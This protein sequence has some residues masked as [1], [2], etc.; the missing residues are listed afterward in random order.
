[1]TKTYH[2]VLRI[3]HNKHNGYAVEYKRE[4]ED[5]YTSAKYWEDYYTK[6]AYCFPT[7]RSV[8]VVNQFVTEE[9]ED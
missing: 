5:C 4:E 2:T 3:E 6:D 9:D 8:V 1:M 7:I